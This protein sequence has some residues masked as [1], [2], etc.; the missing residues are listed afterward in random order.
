MAGWEDFSTHMLLDV[1][2]SNRVRFWHDCWCGSRLLKDRFPMLFECSCDRDAHI[3]VL[4][5]RRSGGASREWNLRFCRD[6]ND[7]EVDEVAAFF[8]LLHIILLSKRM[9]IEFNGV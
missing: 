4:Y 3:D 5:T 1:G 8:H 6:F 9:K 2:V 7:W